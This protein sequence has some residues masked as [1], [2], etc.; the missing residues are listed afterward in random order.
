VSP[1]KLLITA[2]LQLSENYAKGKESPV[3]DEC[4]GNADSSKQEGED[5]KI[6]H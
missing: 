4:S 6:G 5:K 2:A 1:E 3:R